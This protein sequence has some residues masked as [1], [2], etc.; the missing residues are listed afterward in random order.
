MSKKKKNGDKKPK[1]QTILLAT[2][3]IQLLVTALDLIKVAMR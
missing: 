3:I 1:T 2:A